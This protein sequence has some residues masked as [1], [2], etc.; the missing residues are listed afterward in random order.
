MISKIL[1]NNTCAGCGL[2]QSIFGENKISVELNKEGFYRPNVNLNLNKNED[3]LLAKVC[4]AIRVKKD[5][6]ISPKKDV[7][8]GEMFSSFVCSSSDEEIRSEASS[9]GGISAILVY[10]LETK[11]VSAV[12]HIGASK[13]IPYLNDVKI[14]TSR[15][16]IIENANSRYA[17][18]APLQNI[19]ENIREYESYAF[20]GKPCD[21]AAL[22]QYSNHNEEV[23]N[24]IKYY[25][26]FFCAGVPSLN[27]TTDIISAM[28]LKIEDVKSLAYRK[29][30]WP[31]FF[32]I[33]DKTNRIYKLS[34][35]LTWMKLLGPRMQFR[36]KICADAIGHLADIVCADAWEDFDNK[37]FPTFKNAPGKSL[38]ISRT[39]TGEELV[40]EVLQNKDLTFH[41]EI[42]NYREIDKMQ[43]GQFY[44]KIYFLPRY[45]GLLMMNKSAPGFN[46]D[47]YFRATFKS[48]P[49][50]FIKNFLGIMK[51]S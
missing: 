38:L 24:K 30:G 9:G 32:K 35:S 51:R 39:E 15:S 5:K 42:N 36:C 26:S 2:C 34:Y 20:V 46:S 25:I 10:L 22:R 45:L 14:S 31:G 33:T 47:F 19:L 4:P 28:D 41:K 27:A 43:P 29:E 50:A 3:K 7:V 49:M 17:P 13:E 23:R 37:G 8:W 11:K 16:E 12:I 6:T 44:K 1:K 21:V 48:K 18:S 40:L